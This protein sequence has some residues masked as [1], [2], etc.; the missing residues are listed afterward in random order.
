MAFAL[1][2]VLLLAVTYLL[3]RGVGIWDVNIPVAWEFAIVNFVWWI[4]IGH[5]GTLISANRFAEAMT[6][7]AVARAGL[8]PIL[9][10]GRPWFF[11]WVMPYPNT[12][13]LWPQF[14]SR[15]SG[16]SL[17]SRPTGRCRC[18]SGT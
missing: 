1:V 8:F 15:W 6:L 4:G 16:M 9:H 17:P 14:R 10:L 18:C 3:V 5:V 7:L 13:G 2:M 12:M 11:C